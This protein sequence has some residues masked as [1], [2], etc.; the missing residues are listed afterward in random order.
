MKGLI[1]GIEYDDEINDFEN[2]KME[3]V[4][5]GYTKDKLNLTDINLEINK[6]ERVAILG[7]NGAGKT[8]IVKLLLR[9]YDANDG[10][11]YINGRDYKRT[12]VSKLRKIVGAVFQKM[13]EQRIL[14]NIEIILI[15]FLLE[16]F[17]TYQCWLNCA[18]LL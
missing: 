10:T 12:S 16:L 1:E 11:V 4:N 6:G 8:T 15:M 14:S 13:I 17:P 18:F 5:F 9:L 3:H 2:L 7:A